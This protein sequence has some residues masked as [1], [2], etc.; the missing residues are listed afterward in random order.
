MKR[1]LSVVCL[2]FARG[3]AGAET[4]YEP[5]EHTVL[6]LHFD[7]GSGGKAADA[8]ASGLRADLLPEPRRPLWVAEGKFG[9]CLRFDGVN[10]DEDGDGRGDADALWFRDGGKLQAGSGLTVE[11]WIKPEV[12]DRNQG[13]V[14]RSGGAR[15][16]FFVYGTSLY[17]SLQKAG[18]GAA[19]WIRG[20]GRNGVTAG[21]WQ[22]VAVT[23]DGERLRLYRDGHMV[24]EEACSGEPLTGESVTMIGC[25]TDSRPLPS[26]IRGYQGLIDEVRVSNTARTSFNVSAERREAAASRPAKAPAAS[27][28]K[29]PKYADPTV[30]PL[31]RR[32][33][34][35]T[36]RVVDGGGEAVAGVLV[37]DGDLV[38]ASDRTGAFELALE[39]DDLRFVWVTSPTG[40]R[41]AGPWYVPVSRDGEE[42]AL[43]HTFT[44]EPDEGA[45]RGGFSFLTSGDSQFSE[46]GTYTQLLAEYDQLTRMSGSPGFFTVAGDL[47]MSGTQ[48]EMDLYKDVCTRARI[49]VR[50]CFGG[51]DGNYARSTLGRGSVYNYRENLGPAW[52]S[53]DYGP[54]HFVTYVSE[55]YFL[56]DEEQ[57]RQARWLDRDLAAQSEGRPVVLVTHQPPSRGVL[58]DWLAKGNVIGV[59]YGHWHVPNVCGT[60]RVPYID[61]GPMRGRD[62][63]A[64]SRVFRIISYADGRLTSEM[65]VCGQEQ[66]LDIVAPQAE[67]SRGLVPVQVKAYDTITRVRAVECKVSAGGGDTAVELAASGAWTWSG[68]WDARAASPGTYEVSV[69]ALDEHGR[70]W[71]KTARVTLA[72]APGTGVRLAADWPGFFREGHSRVVPDRLTPPLGLAWVTNTGGRNQHAVMPIV[73]GGRVYVGVDCKEIG[74]PGVGVACYEPGDGRRVW[75][76]ATDS[77]VC[78]AAA[79]ADGAVFAV[80]SLG[81]CYCL[82]AGTGAQ[83]W[84]AEPFGSP[85]GH[86]LVRCCPMLVGEEILLTGSSGV[87]PVLDSATGETRREIRLGGGLPYFSFASSDGGRVFGGLRRAAI[88]SDWNTGKKVWVTAISTGK[89]SAT[90]VLS[91]GRLY[92]NAARLSCLDADSGAKLWE[93]A[94][95][96]SGNGI[97]VAAPVGDTVLA[98]GAWLKAFEAETGTLRWEHQYVYDPE[99]AKHNQ[100]QVY[101]GQSTP[102]VA[103]DV[104]YVGGEDG[105][106]YAFALA[107]GEVL[108]RY[109]V[110]VPVKGSPVVSG[111]ALLICDWDGNLFCFTGR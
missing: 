85:S 92:V 87:C 78:F 49:P 5:D 37:S 32:R 27:P 31:N 73:H 70:T 16:C 63:G 103:G 75:H 79:A 104:V 60:E 51:H 83:R 7:E 34:K 36:G 28:D 10:E 14:S 99:T 26:A 21:V 47:T 19:A 24:G 56:T 9:G 107:D 95:P 105:Y 50:N 84:R 89:I 30:P 42:T 97:S 81:S 57:A 80:T 52:Y 77:S 58:D 45:A 102:A 18:T 40:Y 67:V 72:E 86:T 69:S 1:M 20:F 11:A 8:S 106:L 90:P 23:Y 94:V 3:L 22:H 93:Q 111:N 25:D 35:V 98:N 48:W 91:Q 65:R 55:T 17:F 96:T 53:W 71:R 76:A 100:R 110:G 15:Y 12:T 43:E 2:L 41:V 59:V 61:T 101:A 46:V 62:W 82:D 66:R 33:V 6:L 64:F 54:V 4:A 39:V 108:W 44:L 13:L 109:N 74:H 68:V 29:H 38:T 88:A